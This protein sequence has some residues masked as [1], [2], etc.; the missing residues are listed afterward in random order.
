MERL[1]PATRYEL[2]QRTILQTT[3]V[4]VAQA[5]PD[6]YR[7]L[8]LSIDYFKA[9]LNEDGVSM[10]DC[11]SDPSLSKGKGKSKPK[12]NGEGTG[13]SGKNAAGQVLAAK[14]GVAGQT[15]S[16]PPDVIDPSWSAETESSFTGT[17]SRT[18]QS[19]WK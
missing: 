6:A 14:N 2:L 16:A 7:S 13:K 9:F 3:D 19:T 17:W 11:V 5:E 4:A 12:N 18:R 15:L 10:H 1:Q 8:D